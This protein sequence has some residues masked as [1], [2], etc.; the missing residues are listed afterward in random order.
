MGPAA[1]D[2][3]WAWTG[4]GAQAT[5]AGMA[6]SMTT[7]R[8]VTIRRMGCLLGMSRNARGTPADGEVR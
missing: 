3:S 8:A 5:M 6:S 2:A 4:A 7:P 1:G